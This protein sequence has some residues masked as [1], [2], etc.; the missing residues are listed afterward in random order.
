MYIPKRSHA[1]PCAFR[2][3]SFIFPR[4]DVC[5]AYHRH[6]HIHLRL[7]V[8]SLV[9]SQFHVQGHMFYSVRTTGPLQYL[10]ERLEFHQLLLHGWHP[11]LRVHLNLVLFPHLQ[12]YPQI[13]PLTDS[14]GFL[15]TSAQYASSTSPL[16]TAGPSFRAVDASF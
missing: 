3:H 13:R 8:H 6:T 4:L 7:F 2:L 1:H 5:G 15:P 12:S 9:Q 14:P 11:V 16:D 10:P